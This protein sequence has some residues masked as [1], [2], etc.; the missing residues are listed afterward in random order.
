LLAGKI[1][2]YTF[3]IIIQVVLAFGI[4]AI[5]FDMP[6]GNSPLGLVLMAITLGLAAASLGMLV[7]ALARS[8][9]QATSIGMLM[10]FVLGILGGCFNPDTA[11]FRG[12]G[13]MATLSYYTPQ[14]QAMMGYHTLVILKGTL[15]DILPYLGYLLGVSL[16]F[17]LIAIWRFKFE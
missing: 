10:V 16:I 1:I 6:L 13:F 8:R 5:F 2:A 14:A 17:F 3:L 15:I 4:G 7:A 11:P 12:E 9:D